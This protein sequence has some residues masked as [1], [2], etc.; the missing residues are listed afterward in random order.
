MLLSIVTLNYKKAN[1]T[2]S[3]IASLMGQFREEFQD[4]EIELI[5]VDNASND[6]SVKILQDEIK[7]KKYKNVSIIA[8]QE[9]S[10]FGAGNNLGAMAA[11]GKY[12]LFLNNDTQVLDKGILEM[13]NY[14]DQHK[15]VAILGG[16]LRN[17]DGTL[18]ASVGKFYTL[19]NAFLLLLGMQ[20]FG[21]LD[22]SPDRIVEVDWVKGG[23]L[24]IRKE[25]FSKLSGFDEKIFMYTEDMELCYR[26]RKESYKVLFY[27]DVMVIHAEHGSANRSFAIINIYKGLL[28]F[29]KKHR[30]FY[31]FAML[32][33]LLVIKALIAIIIGIITGNSYLTKTY[34]EAINF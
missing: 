23:L 29:Y 24:M 15:E 9:N 7:E 26:A 27:P 20:K 8:N 2:L 30:S 18:Q 33:T 16:Q 6:N 21:L 22:K 4:G 31:E 10:G 17:S 28:Y 1:L 11:K 32:K 19:F 12:I 25:V 3:C 14:I 5:V 34:R 13:A